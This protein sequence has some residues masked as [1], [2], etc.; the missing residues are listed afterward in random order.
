VNKKLLILLIIALGVR[1][2]AVFAIGQLTHRQEFADDAF[3]YGK[4]RAAPLSLLTG[5]NADALEAGGI[6]SPLI[7]LQLLVPACWLIPIFG[8][9][10]GHRLGLLVYDLVAVGVALSVSFSFLGAPQRGLD[11]LMALLL[12]CMPGDILSTCVW[13]QEDTFVAT[14]SA[15]ALWCL[16][17]N[18]SE[19]GMAWT[20]FGLVAGKIFA[21]ISIFA[22][23]C[24][25]R[26]SW[27][28]IT[29]T[30]AAMIGLFLLVLGIRYLNSGFFY[31]SYRY[32]PIYNAPSPWS[33]LWLAGITMEFEQ[34]SPLALGLT[35]SI[36]LI[37]GAV[38]WIRQI[39][40]VYAVLAM[41]TAF[42]ACFVGI[43]PEHYQWILPY[44]IVGAWAFWKN[45]S[46][47]AALMCV[48]LPVLAN[49]YK[50]AYG[51]ARLEQTDPLHAKGKLV[52]LFQELMPLSFGSIQMVL[53]YAIPIVLMLFGIFL[54]VGKRSALLPGKTCGLG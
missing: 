27:R 16:M 43:Q 25:A 37:F 2:V 31:P 48:V 6:Y 51:V 40:V 36:M 7:P 49:G 10:L 44:L 38:I 9:M 15:L 23:W 24:A 5:E 13:G 28:S 3:Y 46:R 29:I 39:H 17:Y 54:L 34:I 18:K 20:G 8:E 41:H 1:C 47:R 11:W 21:V 12:A 22:I 26:K 45:K 53:A 19:A 42:F 4:M 14:W 52:R 30:A 35:G 32:A 33:A 50:I